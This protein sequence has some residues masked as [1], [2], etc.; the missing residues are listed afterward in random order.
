MFIS[1]V[2]FQYKK[3]LFHVEGIKKDIQMNTKYPDPANEEVID[4]HAHVFHLI[5][6]TLCPHPAPQMQTLS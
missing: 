4:A 3:A 1:P 6:S 5:P 2:N